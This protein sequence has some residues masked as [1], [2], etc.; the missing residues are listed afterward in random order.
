MALL[1][2][3][4]NQPEQQ[5]RNAHAFVTATPGG[6]AGIPPDRNPAD[7]AT[8]EAIPFSPLPTPT[9]TA[10]PIPSLGQV[11]VLEYHSL[12]AYEGYLLRSVEGFRAEME[13][14]YESGYTPVNLIEMIQGFPNLPPGAKP[15][16]ITFDDS[17]ISQFR[18]LDDGSLDPDSAVGILYDLHQRHPEEWPLKGTFYVLIDVNGPQRILF[19][20]PEQADKKLRWLVDNGFEVGSHTISHFDLATGSDLQVQYQLG[21]SQRLLEEKAPGY[22]VQSFAVPY[23]SFPYNRAL[24]QQGEWEGRPYTYT[25]N[26]MAWGGPALS[27]YD[28]DFDPFYIS[29]IVTEPDEVAYWFDYFEQNPEL[30]Y[31]VP[32]DNITLANTAAGR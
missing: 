9:P 6:P 32:G 1:A 21:E 11:M 23:G 16:V 7:Q 15:V 2:A 14:L 26:V 10:T 29:R 20:Q 27:P 18:Y 19:G 30:Y 12:G 25:S 8:P 5:P 17:D 4:N 22:D 24:L 3:C 31:T 28:P 13:R